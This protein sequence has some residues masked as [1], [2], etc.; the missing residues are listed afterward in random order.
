[1]VSVGNGSLPQVHLFT[2]I[3]HNEETFMIKI[4]DQFASTL[5][6]ELQSFG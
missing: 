2:Y 6:T 1:M 3:K 4:N 5:G